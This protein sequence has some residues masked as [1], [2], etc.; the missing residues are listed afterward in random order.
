MLP[1]SSESDLSGVTSRVNQ[2]FRDMRS[3]RPVYI[4]LVPDN[5]IVRSPD[6]AD[7]QN[8]IA[9]RLPTD[10]QLVGRDVNLLI[11]LV[12]APPGSVKSQP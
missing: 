1:F 11:F 6:G 3:H 12:P 8:K 10:Y 5:R 7:W 4:V 2:V 9:S